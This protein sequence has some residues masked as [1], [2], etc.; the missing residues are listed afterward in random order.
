MVAPRRAPRH[1]QVDRLVLA[2]V[3]RDDILR[4]AGPF[5]VR[6]RV[7]KADAVE[8]VLEAPQVLGQ[9]EC[10]A[11]VDRNHFVDAVAKNEAAV[12]HRYPGLLQRHELAIQINDFTHPVLT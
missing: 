9:P 1:L 11:R 4:E 5:R 12:Q 3:A 8:A 10:M 7:G 2:G 6:H